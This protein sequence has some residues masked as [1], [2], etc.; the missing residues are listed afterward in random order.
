ML[1]TE[2]DSTSVFRSESETCAEMFERGNRAASNAEIMEVTMKESCTV[3]H[4]FGGTK[5]LPM[6]GAWCS[7][8]ANFNSSHSA[9]DDEARKEAAIG[10]V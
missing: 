9:R 5:D 1:V 3:E 4:W 2:D 7:R 8:G 10:N 6:Y